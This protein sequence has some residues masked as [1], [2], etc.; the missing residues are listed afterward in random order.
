M[1]VERS[2]FLTI[3]QKTN[4][5]Q[6]IGKTVSLGSRIVIAF[7]IYNFFLS[8]SYS[9]IIKSTISSFFLSLYSFFGPSAQAIDASLL[10]NR[11]RLLQILSTWLIIKNIIVIFFSLALT[12]VNSVAFLQLFIVPFY[13][14][15][16]HTK[17]ICIYITNNICFYLKKIYLYHHIYKK[18]FLHFF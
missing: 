18:T 1:F 5:D 11:T 9:L 2:Y 15:T 7:H 8:L 12:T 14:Q 4:C 16:S 13:S 6:L 10:E 3:F 17:Y